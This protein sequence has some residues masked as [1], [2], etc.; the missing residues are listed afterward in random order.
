MDLK[1][2][3]ALILTI[4][5]ITELRVGLPLAVN[6]AIEHN[7]NIILIFFV[8][9]FLNILMIFFVFYFLDN[10]HSYLLRF[11]FYRKVFEKI[12]IRLRKKTDKFEKKYNSI[13]FLAL[14]L[15]VAIPLPGTGIYTGTLI[16]WILGLERKR[17]IASI[18]IGVVIAGILVLLGTLGFIKLFS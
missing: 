16:S 7:I 18:S 13:G 4:I 8:I 10:I 6:Y 15:L 11:H 9:I 14:V 12:L 17:S 1:L 3:Y 2:L 5:P